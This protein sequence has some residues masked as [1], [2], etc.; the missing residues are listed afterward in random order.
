MFFLKKTCNVRL[1]LKGYG[2]KTRK[3]SRCTVSNET[4]LATKQK[5]FFTKVA[6]VQSIT[7]IVLLG[8]W[9]IV[10]PEFLFHPALP[11]IFSWIFFKCLYFSEYDI[12][13]FLLVFWLRNRP[14]IK[15]ERNWQNGG[16]RVHSKCEQEC[17][18]EGDWKIGRKIHTY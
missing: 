18:G 3:V 17:T 1:S 6:P 2:S 4:I 15:Y 16:E 9:L 10:L 12:Q 5:F 11:F 13:M 7:D 14:S 8:F